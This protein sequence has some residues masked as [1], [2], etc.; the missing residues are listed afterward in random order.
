MSAITERRDM[1]LYEV[2]LYVLL[3]SLLCYSLHLITF[4]GKLA[5]CTLVRKQCL[6]SRLESDQ[7]ESESLWLIVSVSPL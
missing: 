5:G 3:R 7:T 2:P 6:D 1:G 4:S